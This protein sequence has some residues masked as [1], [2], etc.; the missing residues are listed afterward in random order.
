MTVYE[1]FIFHDFLGGHI[2]VFRCGVHYANTTA[3]GYVLSG[4]KAHR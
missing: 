3:Y 2:E 4:N 1:S